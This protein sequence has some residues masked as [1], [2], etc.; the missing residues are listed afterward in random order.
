[1][2][3]DQAREKRDTYRQL[4]KNG[5]DPAEFQKSEKQIK[6]EAEAREI[7]ETRFSLDNK[8]SLSIRLGNRR[9]DLTSSETIEL[10]LF[11]DATRN[12]EARDEPCL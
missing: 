6:R 5:H 9:V 8:G 11:L 2:S 3:P 7:A 12:V 4:L 10:R 1:M